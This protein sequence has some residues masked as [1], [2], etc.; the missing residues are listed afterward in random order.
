MFISRKSL[1]ILASTVVSYTL[2]YEAR[3]VSITDTHYTDGLATS[4]DLAFGQGSAANALYVAYGSFDGGANPKAWQ[5]LV[6][7][8]DIAPGTSTYTA[9]APAGWGPSVNAMRFFMAE[10][11]DLP[12][13]A[14]LEY[15]F[16]TG[17]EYADTGYL[18]T[19]NT[20]VAID[21]VKA[22]T[23]YGLR[24]GQDL[25]G[26]IDEFRIQDGVQS[27]AYISS[28]YATQ[29]DPDFLTYGRPHNTAPT[30]LILR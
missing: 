22:N 8:A 19:S 20:S 4:F 28:D 7:L 23:S 2:A 15:V 27:A 29:T 5:N 14:A 18:A 26:R 13:D 1:F 10:I 3:T 6:K 12:Y 9:A 21:T 30:M 24:F 16:T 11:A 17:A 25:T